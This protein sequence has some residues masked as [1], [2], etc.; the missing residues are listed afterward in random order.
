MSLY[1]PD[2]LTSRERLDAGHDKPARLAVIGHPVAHSLSPRMH[3]PALDEAGIDARYIKV[4]VEPGQVAETF[5]RMRELGF[6]GCNVTVPHKFEALAAC[7]EVDAGAAEMGVVNTV[8]FD[9]DA[10]RG[11][12]TDGYGFEEAARE[13]LGLPLGGASVLI[14][15]AGGG[16]GGAIAVHCARQGVARLILANRSVEKIEE[17][18][19]RIRANHGGV[20]ILT[21]GLDD[22]RLEAWAKSADLIVNTSS[23]GLKESDPSPVPAAYFTSRHSAYDTIYRPGTAFQQAAAAAGA[24][25]GT[26]REMLLHQGVK[27]FQIW[28]PGTDPVA[29]MRHGLAAG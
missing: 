16:A 1:S 18:A 19:D 17:L 5:R 12:N 4:E 10:T 24:K 11:F 6:A 28:F 29:A 25:V 26:G 13:T 9:A 15:G 22:P 23:L 7:D 21:A 20:E 14:A 3:Q 27:A 8:R 2:D